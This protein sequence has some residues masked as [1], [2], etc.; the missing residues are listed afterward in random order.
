MAIHLAAQQQQQQE[1]ARSAHTPLSAMG[2]GKAAS[3]ADLIRAADAAHGV[4]PAGGARGASKGSWGPL[5]AEGFG[6]SSSSGSRSEALAR[7]VGGDLKDVPFEMLVLEVL[8]DATTGAA[9]ATLVAC[10]HNSLFSHGVRWCILVVDCS[11]ARVV[12]ALS[13]R[14]SHNLMRGVQTQRPSARDAPT[15]AVHI[16]CSNHH[17]LRLGF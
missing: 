5:E 16:V 15:A 8:L 2:C 1:A 3:A 17:E 4:G 12:S 11:I 9:A 6:G 13:L 10:F 7:N 14:V